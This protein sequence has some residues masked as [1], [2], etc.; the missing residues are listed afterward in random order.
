V[1]NAFGNVEWVKAYD[2]SVQDELAFVTSC[3]LEKD[4][5]NSLQQLKGSKAVKDVVN[6]IRVLD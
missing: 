6:A 2:A 4:Y 1:E 5:C 3:V